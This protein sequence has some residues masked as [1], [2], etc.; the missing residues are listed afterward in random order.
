MRF[1]GGFQATAG[2]AAAV[3]MLVF[4]ASAS[5]A[6]LSSH[7][8]TPSDPT[9]VQYNDDNASDPGNTF[10]ISGTT[11]DDGTPGNV[12]IVCTEGT[13]SQTF[14]SNVPVTYTGT[15]GTFSVSHTLISQ[16]TEQT[17]RLHAVPAG[18]TPTDLSPFAG[19]RLGISDYQTF[20]YGGGPENGKQYD[21]YLSDSQLTGYGDYESY[22]NG[23]MYDAEPL[24][25]TTF[26]FGGDVF[27]ANDTYNALTK[28]G[29]TRS[30]VQVDGA[31][32]FGAASAEFL[33]GS[34]CAFS[35]IPVMTESHSYDPAT[36][37]LTIHESEPLVKCEP[38]PTTYPPTIGTSCT[39]FAPTGVSVSRVIQQ[40]AGGRQSSLIDT[41]TSTDGAAHHLDL[42]SIE[43]AQESTAGY[44]FPWI[45]GSTYSTHTAGDTKS[46]PPS[47][48]ASVYVEWENTL[49]DGDENG[50]QGAIT[51]GQAPNG[52]AFASQGDFGSTHLQALYTRT[53]PASGSLTLSQMFS[54]AFTKADAH[55]LA[56]QAQA[57]LQSPA[58]AI[59]SP[60]NG[61]ALTQTPTTVT[62]TASA[63][64]GQGGLSSVT[65]DGHPVTV[66]ANGS[67]ST[68]VPLSSGSNTIAAVATDG[69]GEQSQAQTTVTYT[70]VI[71]TPPVPAPH[72]RLVHKSFN[73]KAVVARLACA[74]SGSKCSGK[75][76]LTYKATVVTVHH[77]KKHKHKVR[78][79]VGRARYSINAGQT[80]QRHGAAKRHWQAAS[81]EAAHA[82][83]VR[84][85][86]PGADQW[87]QS[88]RDQVHDEAQAAEGE[89]APQVSARCARTPRRAG[90]PAGL[91]V[92]R[93]D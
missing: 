72:E 56:A 60:S 17:C 38:D 44:N 77:G 6:V 89:D 70:P 43:D 14:E 16:E 76:T 12:D 29:V 85:R 83:R 50:A 75:I 49:A 87:S 28:S 52:F 90:R 21:F 48:P 71:H 63:S 27:Y 31:N 23:G 58:V 93:G 30:S 73:G 47:A 82:A 69:N 59:T 54:W 66:A 32:A 19:P 11:V 35:G 61:T 74:A 62:G 1:Y 33:C 22:T 36:G 42:V 37:G 8:T 68:S 67:W 86:D 84:R 13:S 39:S 80:T 79:M 65:V 9:F 40:D 20:T 34:T 92:T 25:P 81:Q 41:Y 18:T 78:F 46:A 7:I 53:V 5:A 51:F 26:A 10:T 88:D 57:A 4:S 55:T 2:L 24:D 64:A 45:D 91:T 15:S 3:A